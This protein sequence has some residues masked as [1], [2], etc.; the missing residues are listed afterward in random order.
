[1]E[2]YLYPRSRERGNGPIADHAK[3]EMLFGEPRI[4]T[5]N[6][7]SAGSSRSTQSP[8]ERTISVFFDRSRVRG[9]LPDRRSR[10]QEQRRSEDG[11]FGTGHRFAHRK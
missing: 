3:Q 4:N 1:M 5:S 8:V 10:D 9:V 7:A 11:R 6:G 2:A